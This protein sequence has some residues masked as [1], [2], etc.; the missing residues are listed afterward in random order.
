MKRRDFFHN[1]ALTTAGLSFLL[2][3]QGNVLGNDFDVANT[4]GKKKKAKNI[5][6]LVSDGMSMGTLTLSELYLKRKLGKESNW[7]N[8]YRDK[9]VNRSLM[10]MASASSMVTDS[11]AASSSWGGGHR[12]TNGRLNIGPNGEEYVPILQKFK[13]AGKRVGCVT[14]VP[15]THATPAGFCIN[16]KSRGEQA[17]IAEMYLD[18]HFDVMMGGG[19]KYFVNTE[20]GRDLFVDFTKKGYEVLRSTQ[21]M[22]KSTGD[23]PILGVFDYEALPYELDRQQDPLKM[24]TIPSLKEM[25]AKAI[26]IMKDHKDGFCLQVEGG[27][28]D[29]AAHANDAFALIHDQIAFDEAVAVAIDF[30]EKDKNTLVII[31]TDHGNS[32]PALYYGKNTDKHFESIFQVKHTTDFILQ[33]VERDEKIQDFIDRV[34]HYQ[35]YQILPEEAASLLTTYKDQKEGGTYNHYNLPFGAYAN[36]MKKHTSIQFGGNDHT[37]DY[38]ELAMFGPGSQ[39]LKPFIKNTDLH[40]FMLEVAEVEHKI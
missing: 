32:N 3:F 36:I 5:I 10:D 22:N 19:E 9:R 17:D 25:T 38:V 29:W 21:D 16:A 12:V 37:S 14:T 31:T 35:G 30:A 1:T 18:L 33:S 20:K 2:P 39:Q 28:V 34:Y 7:L 24:E 26:E 4:L 13:K 11:S 6:F 8:L 40:Y 27:K 23:K 15:I